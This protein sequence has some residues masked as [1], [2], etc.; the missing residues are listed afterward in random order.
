M[1]KFRIHGGKK[2]NGTVEINGA[3]N[4]AVAI[5]PAALMAAGV[6]RIENVPDIADV[7]A[8]EKIL[9]HLGCKVERDGS[10]LII[11][12]TNIVRTDAQTE[13]VKSMR[14]SYYLIGALIGRFHE[15]LVSTQGGCSIGTRPIDQHLKGFEKLGVDIEPENEY[16]RAKVSN[17]KGT[18]VY[19]DVISVGATINVMMAGVMAEGTTTL[20]NA[21]KE[22]HVVDVANFLNTMGA[23]IRGAGTDVIKIHGQKKLHG[24]TYSVIPDQIEAATFMIAAAGCGGEVTVANIIPKHLE[25]ISSK[26]EEMGVGIKIWEDTIKVKSTGRLDPVNVKT[27]AYPGFPTDV[28]QPMSV[29]M[30]VAEGTSTINESI[31]ENRF[32][33]LPELGKM[34]AKFEIEYEDDKKTAHVAHIHGVEKLVG[35]EVEATDLRAGAALIIA[36]LI[37][38]GKTD[39]TEIYHIDRGYPHIEKKFASL[40]AQIERVIE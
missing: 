3:K 37:A 17:L 10:T 30:T 19:F 14:G 31:Y 25:S 22:P 40:G 21:A 38:E 32:N 12:S 16:I 11:D 8:Y 6:C 36:G 2:L 34:G 15:A 4:A 7:H 39:I 9:Q 18:H 26:L 13:E 23:D 5:L 27:Q 35:T 33:H 29:L 28:Q 24:C 1:E 20:E